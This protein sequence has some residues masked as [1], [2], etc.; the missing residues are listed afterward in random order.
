MTFLRHVIRRK[1]TRGSE[2]KTREAED[3]VKLI[4]IEERH[5]TQIVEYKKRRGSGQFTSSTACLCGMKQLF[6]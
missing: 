1:G 6:P 5:V 2:L 3:T 4:T